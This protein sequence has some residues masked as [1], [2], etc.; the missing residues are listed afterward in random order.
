MAS[1]AAEWGISF[2]HDGPRVDDR[3]AAPLRVLCRLTGPGSSTKLCAH[4]VRRAAISPAIYRTPVKAA[5]TLGWLH[6]HALVDYVTAG[7]DVDGSSPP[8]GGC[9][10][11]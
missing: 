7:A 11:E 8:E 9:G 10:D 3:R 2:E 6:V 4:E 1:V 5:V